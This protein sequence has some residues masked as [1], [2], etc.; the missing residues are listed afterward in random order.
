MC[1]VLIIEGD[2]L[3]A[4]HMA[5]VIEDAGADTIEQATDEAGAVA[6]ARGRRPDLIVSE[7]RLADGSGP[8]AIARILEEHGSVPVIFVTGTPEACDP[9]EPPIVILTKPVADDDLAATFRQ[10]VRLPE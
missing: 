5:L 9:C 6:A 10:M 4:D 7:V 1:H 2:Y 3:L 8:G